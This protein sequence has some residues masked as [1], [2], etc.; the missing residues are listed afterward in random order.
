MS[1]RADTELMYV[2][3][4]Q[5]KALHG[6]GWGPTEATEIDGLTPWVTPPA[7]FDS[8]DYNGVV[9]LVNPPAAGATANI[10]QFVVP[11][12]YDGVIKRISHNTAFGGFVN[13]S[14]DIRWRILV[15]GVAARNYNNMLSEMGSQQIP[16]EIAGIRVFSGQTVIYQC[17]HLANGALNGNVVATMGGWFYPRR[18]Q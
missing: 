5:H 7:G 9:A 1:N 6:V 4:M 8:F 3:E 14:G 12:A 11:A 13:G 16:R 17:T 10:I 2:T 15:G 18:G